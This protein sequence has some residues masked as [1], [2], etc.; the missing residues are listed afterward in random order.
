[1]FKTALKYTAI[2]FLLMLYINRGLFVT[3]AEMNSN[4]S[5]INSLTELFVEF[6][7]GHSNNIDEDGNLQETCN[8]A[9]NIQ[10]LIAQQFSQSLELW[11]KFPQKT[12][13][14]YFPI[15]EN[16]PN[17]PILGQIDH[18]PCC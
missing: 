12:E 6:I 9:K 18:P 2:A 3:P 16:I 14:L 10:P 4:P 13:K 15:T 7:T 8:S 1:M 5:E 17:L 11:N